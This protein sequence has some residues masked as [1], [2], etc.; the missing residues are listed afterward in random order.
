MCQFSPLSYIHY[1]A[2]HLHRL[3]R[4][5]VVSHPPQ[6]YRLYEILLKHTQLLFWL[7]YSWE[8][9]HAPPLVQLSPC[10]PHPS[11]NKL[12]RKHKINISSK[13]AFISKKGLE[14]NLEYMHSN[15]FPFLSI[16]S[17]RT[18]SET[19]ERQF[20]QN[21]CYKNSFVTMVTLWMV[22]IYM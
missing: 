4:M 5:G 19:I 17:G 18:R 14:C 10:P 15:H 11:K 13:S 9:A 8:G 1:A 22:P 6:S 7:Y 12:P 2:F 16:Y 3:Q 20:K 21:V